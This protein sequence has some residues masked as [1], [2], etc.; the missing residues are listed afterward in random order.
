MSLVEELLNKLP[1]EIY[2]QGE[3]WGELR[4]TKPLFE[5]KV[6]YHADYIYTYSHIDSIL[7]V[8]LNFSENIEKALTQLYDCLVK[9]KLIPPVLEV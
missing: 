5:G 8:D 4:I 7:P 3:G 1:S 2:V 6:W 9:W